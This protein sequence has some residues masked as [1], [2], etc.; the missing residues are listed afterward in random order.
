MSCT[1]AQAPV[2]R[3]AG[4]ILSIAGVAGLVTA[5]IIAKTSDTNVTYVSVTSALVSLAGIG[6]FMAGDL[7]G[8][9]QSGVAV[10]ASSEPDEATKHRWAQTW[11]GRAQEAA[12]KGDCERVQSIE[13]RVA[14]L[15]PELHDVVLMRDP[16]IVKCLHGEA[17]STDTSGP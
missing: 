8:Q 1:H 7:S 12:Q 16:Q 3:K 9:S 6:L 14:R 11:L 13:Q 2:A 15:D 5:G 4:E 10:A 17:S